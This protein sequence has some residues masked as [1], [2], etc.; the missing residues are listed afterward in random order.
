[1]KATA[2]TALHEQLEKLLEARRYAEAELACQRLLQLAPDWAEAHFLHAMLATEQRRWSAAVTNLRQALA[3][4]PAPER[5]WTQLARLLALT[6]RIPEAL[7]AAD[8][9]LQRQPL[10]A[11]SLD[12]LGVVYSR[13]NLHQRAATLFR[14]ASSLEPGNPSYQFNLA[15]ALKFLGDF[16]GAETAYEA[17]LAA[18]PDCWKAYPSLSQLR[19][20]TPER[21]HRARYE[22]LLP[23]ARSVD[24]QLQLR[25][26]LAKECED[27]GEAKQAF[28]HLLLGKSAKRAS[29]A[30]DSAEDAALFS[31]L[32][33]YFEGPGLTGQ[34]SENSE[35]IFV[36]GMPRTGTTLVERILSSHSQVHAA[37]ELQNLGLVTKRLSGSTTPRLLDANTLAGLHATAA[38]QI[39]EAYVNSTRPG[40][41]HTPRF[42][43]KMPLNFL[44]VGFIAQALP[45]AKIIC[46]RRNPLDTCLSNFRQLFALQFSY[47]NYSYDLL[48]T[49]RYYLLFHRLMAFWRQR[50]PA[51][52]LEVQYETL[53][54]S[55]EAETRRLLDW[56][57][58]PWEEACLHFENNQ[59]AV[60]TASA[61]QVRQPI[62]RSSVDR[63]KHLQAE[64]QP[65]RQLLLA[66]GVPLSD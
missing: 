35:P 55:P 31:A 23:R 42:V 29:L 3:I 48:D 45:K 10:Q 38:R 18:D 22:A 12:T 52:V 41:G 33:K 8:Q 15:S 54:A 36:V 28:Q 6:Q 11:W 9:A 32:Q 2:A 19:K 5:Y 53:V 26:A 61:V 37:G 58:L 59:A 49:G 21:N 17:C 34:G 44:Y 27:L 60:S 40:T 20:Q 62:Y 16:E 30:Y 25:M 46:L 63:W 47:Y 57:D 39:G 4:D 7:A 50:F 14:Q 43:D 51:A 1:M 24:A 65:L 56:C 66:G 13:A 64:L